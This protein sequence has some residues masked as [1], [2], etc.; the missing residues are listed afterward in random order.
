MVNTP[1]HYRKQKYKSALVKKGFTLIELLVVISI[2]ALLSSIVLFAVNSARAKAR[3]VKRVSDVKQLGKAVEL[4]YS[5][6]GSYPVAMVPT[7]TIPG[8]IPTYTNAMPKVPTPIEPGCTAAQNAY[9]YQSDGKSYG[10]TF[11]AGKTVGSIPAGYDIARSN[12]VR[13]RYDLDGDG[14][15]NSNDSNDEESCTIGIAADW[16]SLDQNDVTGNGV[17]DASDIQA[18]FNYVAN[19]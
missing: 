5:T 17:V 3:D 9:M 16:C 8:I 15:I 10:I 18:F 6:N 11:C 7:A 13:K 4:Y 2:I 14:I 12:I 19:Q 1:E